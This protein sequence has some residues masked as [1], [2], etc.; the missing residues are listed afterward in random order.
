MTMGIYKITNTITEDFYIGSSVNM[1]DRWYN[2][3]HGAHNGSVKSPHL[4]AAM[5]KYGIDKF[6]FNPLIICEKSELYRYEQI[7]LNQNYGKSNCYNCSP[8]ADAP[9]RGRKMSDEA[10]RNMSLAGIGRIPW[11]KGIPRTADEKKNISQKTKDAMSK[12]D[13]SCSKETKVKLSKALR[14]RVMSTDTRKKMSLAKQGIIPW[15]LNKKHPASAKLNEFQVANIRSK[16]SFGVY[17][18]KRLATEYNV[19]V[20]TIEAIIKRRTWKHII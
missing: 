14:G 4:Y 20:R 2:H 1:S 3:K 18:L 6:N 19:H 16:Y 8:S 13:N 11:N 9:W 15:N 5:R 17:G 10:R 12:L 7:L